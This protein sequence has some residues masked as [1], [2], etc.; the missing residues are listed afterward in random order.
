MMFDMLQYLTLLE[1]LHELERAL[2]LRHLDLH[3][4]LCLVH[5]GLHQLVLALLDKG[6]TGASQRQR[7]QHVR[8]LTGEHKAPGDLLAMGGV[9]LYY[10]TLTQTA[11]YTSK[12]SGFS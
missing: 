10:P 7:A 11:Q 3:R 4:L 2:N 8:G 1:V 6:K 5:V 9:W 12:P